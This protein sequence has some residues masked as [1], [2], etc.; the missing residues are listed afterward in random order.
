M[1]REDNEKTP[2][3]RTMMAGP[4]GRFGAY[5]MT[6][7]FDVAMWT[8]TSVFTG[9]SR[10]PLDVALS[11]RLKPLTAD[12]R[13]AV[14]SLTRKSVIAALHGFLHGVSHD[15][16]LI[17][18][19]FDGADVAESSDGLQGDLFFWIRDLSKYP[20]DALSETRP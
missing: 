7:S 4:V 9:T 17:Q 20:H 11:E 2:Y 5:L 16:T 12:E 18:L 19:K 6:R 13:D 8:A 3:Y 14:M 15:E 10:A 1:T